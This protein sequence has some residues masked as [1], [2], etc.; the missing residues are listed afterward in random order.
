[1]LGVTCLAYIRV[2]IQKMLIADEGQNQVSEK[3]SIIP[4]DLFKILINLSKRKT[5]S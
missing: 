2:A 4:I 3:L 5:L 1:M